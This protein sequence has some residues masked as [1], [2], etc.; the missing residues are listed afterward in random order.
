MSSHTALLV[1]QK[2]EVPVTTWHGAAT[3]T[4]GESPAAVAWSSTRPC[5]FFVTAKL[6][7]RIASNY[8]VSKFSLRIRHIA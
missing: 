1:E 4:F 8:A 6:A 7:Y 3:V 2:F 5:V